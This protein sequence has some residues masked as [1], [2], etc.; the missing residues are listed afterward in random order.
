MGAGDFGELKMV[1]KTEIKSE[2]LLVQLI[3]ALD[4]Y[5]EGDHDDTA[6][7]MGE[8]IYAGHRVYSAAC[9]L[10][11]HCGGPRMLPQPGKRIFAQLIKASRGSQPIESIKYAGELRD[12][13][14]RKVAEFECH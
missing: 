10:E 9:E 12:W 14:R 1:Q 13:A 7:S 2:A 6:S 4:I 8:P 11:T 3:E 5:I